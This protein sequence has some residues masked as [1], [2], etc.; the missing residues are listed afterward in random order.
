M[1]GNPYETPKP[2]GSPTGPPGGPG[3]VNPM[4]AVKIPAIGLAVT[5]G[6]SIVV[7]I[8]LFVLN[9]MGIAMVA[10][11][12]EDPN[13]MASAAGGVVGMIIGIILNG[14]VLYGGLE[15]MKLKNFNLAMG[16]SILAVIPCCSPCIILGIPFGIWSLVLLNKPEIKSAFR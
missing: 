7:R 2:A 3:A 4:E 16:A 13:A 9:M 11:A 6:V 5:A 14:V 8:I 1:S 10:G 12:A 15:M